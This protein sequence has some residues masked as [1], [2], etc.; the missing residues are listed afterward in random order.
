M[1]FANGYRNPSKQ[2][3]VW[4]GEYS[5]GSNLTEFD[6][7]TG[8]ENRFVS[9]RK[10]CLIRF[11][12][13]GQ[14]LSFYHEVLGGTFKLCGRMIDILLKDRDTGEEY[15]LT[16]LS[17]VYND[18]IAYKDAEAVMY[19]DSRLNYNGITQFNFGYKIPLTFKDGTEVRFKSICHIP[20]GSPVYMTLNIVT[21]R[22]MPKGVLI[23]KKNGI[24]VNNFDVSI[25]KNIAGELN[26][27]LG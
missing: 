1:G 14:G 20:N 24:E 19:S 15:Y 4:V 7:M 21:N 23:I 25:R 17:K 11:G 12:L 6:M 9:L 8:K 27:V 26:W 10:D 22:D 18:V 16:G 13:V 5:D 3:F 2:G